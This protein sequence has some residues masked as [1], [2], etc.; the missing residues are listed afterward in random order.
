MTVQY[1]TTLHNLEA[2][3]DT[4]L[5]VLTL[6]DTMNS[7]VN[8]QL[9]WLLEKL[10]GAQDGLRLLTTV[11][12]NVLLLLLSCLILLFLRAPW[13]SRAS[14]L[15]LVVLNVGSEVYYN[16]SLSLAQLI[17][18]M[19]I[20]SLGMTYVDASILV[21]W[22]YLWYG[23]YLTYAP[24]MSISQAPPQAISDAPP[25]DFKPPTIDTITNVAMD[26]SDEEVESV[27]NRSG[28]CPLIDPSPSK[29]K[30]H[31]RLFMSHDRLSVSCDRFSVSH[32]STPLLDTLTK[33]GGVTRNGAKCR[34]R[35]LPGRRYCRLHC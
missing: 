1:E 24:P 25:T 16:T 32:E 21:E 11:A 2:I 17:T 35:A 33:C 28:Y 15:G 26:A 12:S 19:A 23:R 7:A 8:I 34:R 13:V 4:V 5:H 18:I 20:V 31:D 22:C 10:G 30:S 27:L 6:L 29:A 3:N 14:L 9:T